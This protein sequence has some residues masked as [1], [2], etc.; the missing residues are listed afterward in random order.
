[1]NTNEKE[2]GN[3][4]K[5]L[6]LALVMVMTVSLLASC[7][8]APA[9]E[10]TQ[11]S[12]ADAGTEAPADGE[13]I[14]IGA[15]A[16]VTGDSAEMGESM[17]RTLEIAFEDINA[18]GGVLGKQVELVL[19]DSK[20]DPKEAVE[21]AKKLAEAES[22]VAVIGPMMSS[23][24]IACA[25]IF[26]EYGLVELAPVASN[27]EYAT[28]SE[29]SFT[30]AGRQS[31]EMPYFVE[32]VLGGHVG[33]ESIGVVWINDDWG[34]SSIES[35]QAAC[36]ELGI[37]VASSESYN[38]GEKDFNAV[39]TKIR[40]TNPEVLVL[41]TQAADGSLI[42]NQIKAMGWDIPVVG[43]GALYSDQVIELAGEMA[44]GLVA[45]SAF[46]LSEED[47]EAWDY[48]QRFSEGAGFSPT[49]HGTYD[50]AFVLAAAIEHA[51]STD[52]EAIRVALTEI[53]GVEG[54]AGSYEFTEDGDII[55]A[56]RVLEVVD[57]AW[58]AVTDYEV[59]SMAK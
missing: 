57:G 43:V 16:P 42:L 41:A 17:W 4:K 50:A 35:M 44:E 33:A 24:A 13:V 12:A 9:A 58:T 48:A 29:Y 1:M 5:L 37:E 23:E 22:I 51:G 49:I 19:E 40:Q 15:I 26:D 11:T 20:G 32:K 25:P 38:A 18:A 46:F 59:A 3:M 56:Y 34:V 55:R 45:P 36:D 28:M 54:L 8:S 47:A 10:S 53:S 21:L 7:S 14:R 52:R 2:S 6:L 27:N 39:L 31:A 30:L